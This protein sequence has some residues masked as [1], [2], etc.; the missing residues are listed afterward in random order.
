MVFVIRHLA[1]DADLA[2]FAQYLELERGDD[3][4]WLVTRQVDD[5][6]DGARRYGRGA[7]LMDEAGMLSDQSSTDE[8]MTGDEFTELIEAGSFERAWRAA[9]TGGGQAET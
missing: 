3:G 4:R 2:G 9:A 5:R 8:E 6:P 1:V 7:S